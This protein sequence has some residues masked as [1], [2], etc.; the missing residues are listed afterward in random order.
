MT[1]AMLTPPDEENPTSRK[2]KIYVFVNSRSGLGLAVVALSEDGYFL[3][4]HVSSSEGWAKHDMGL[5]GSSWKHSRY[6]AHFG[7]GNW[8]LEWIPESE[9]L[10]H[11]GVEAAYGI[12]TNHNPE[13]YD[14]HMKAVDLKAKEFDDRQE[15][16]FDVQTEIQ[17]VRIHPRV[18]CVAVISPGDWTAY[19]VPVPGIDHESEAEAFWQTD[20]EKLSLEIAKVIFPDLSMRCNP[21]NYRK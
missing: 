3:A 9:I 19:C 10:G 6:N 8:E 13:A 20:G 4:Q 17:F 21:I 5:N 18:L 15:K 12:H 7:F 2:R 16:N 11:P 14:S 1:V